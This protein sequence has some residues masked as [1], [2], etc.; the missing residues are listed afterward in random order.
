MDNNIF[1][2]YR[3]QVKT[4]KNMQIY[5][6]SR[7]I[8]KFSKVGDIKVVRKQLSLTSSVELNILRQSL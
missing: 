6:D 5:K 7:M 3:A 1:P 8:S 4:K 2:G